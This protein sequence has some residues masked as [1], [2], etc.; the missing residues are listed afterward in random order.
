[1]RRLRMIYRSCLFPLAVLL[2][3]SIAGS[4]VVLGNTIIVDGK[5]TKVIVYRDR[6]MVFRQASVRLTPGEHQILFKH[7]PATILTDSLHV[8]AVSDFAKIVGVDS[9]PED[10]VE[11]KE[12]RERHLLNQLCRLEDDLQIILDEEQTIEEQIGFLRQVGEKAAGAVAEEL[13]KGGGGQFEWQELYRNLAGQI[14]SHRRTIRDLV[15]KKRDLEKRINDI[16]EQ[17]ANVE[18]NLTDTYEIAVDVEAADEVS[19]EIALSYVTQGAGWTPEYDVRYLEDEESL[20]V[21]YRA[22]VRQRTGE[23]WPEVQ[24]TLSTGKPLLYGRPKELTPWT[25]GFASSLKATTVS[26]DQADAHPAQASQPSSGGQKADLGKDS[27]PL[28]QPADLGASDLVRKPDEIA[29]S[30]EIPGPETISSGTDNNK[31]TVANFRFPARLQ[32]IAIPRQGPYTFL[33]AVMTNNSNY[34]LLSGE[35]NVFLGN[36]F[37]SST[38]IHTTMPG[39]AL[40]FYLGTDPQIE[41]RQ[42]ELERSLDSSGLIVTTGQQITW[43]WRLDVFNRR[44]SQVIL[45]IV[46]QVPIPKSKD[47]KLEDF[48]CKDEEYTL[49]D[50]GIVRWIFE[51]APKEERTIL[52]S[53]KI[54]F[55]KDTVLTG[56]DR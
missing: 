49:E 20:D 12:T 28:F 2:A 21:S 14:R 42:T 39:A 32:Y 11:Q 48:R 16:N 36:D 37:L 3:V 27:A 43:R 17:I 19:G 31:V 56:L 18:E 6:A 34:P 38:T 44:D 30:F 1:V 35:A 15:P 7:L 26:A 50:N 22:N 29:F 8:S 53:Y 47:I 52:Y 23:P 45:E 13:V 9:R 33:R 41:V 55:P 25:I 5:T 10:P 24:L 46:D 40:D 4:H 51:L 54:K